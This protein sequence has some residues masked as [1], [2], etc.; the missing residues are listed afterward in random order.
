MYR[1]KQFTELP[2]IKNLSAEDQSREYY[3][4]QNKMMEAIAP[5]AASSAAAGAGGAGGSRRQ[6][7]T[8]ASATIH[9]RLLNGLFEYTIINFDLGTSVSNSKQFSTDANLQDYFGTQEGGFIFWIPSDTDAV[10]HIIYIDLSGGITQI[11]IDYS[12]DIYTAFLPKYIIFYY[13]EQLVG[14]RLLVF[15]ESGIRKFTMNDSITNIG[16]WGFDSHF[17]NGFCIETTSDNI[18][19]LYSV[20]DGSSTPNMIQQMDNDIN[21]WNV[22]MHD[23]HEKIMIRRSNRSLD[24]IDEVKVID[25]NGNTLATLDTRNLASVRYT[26]QSGDTKSQIATSQGCTV[27]LLEYLNPTY[28]LD[29]LVE[30]DIING[31]VELYWD[32]ITYLNSNDNI[33]ILLST[34]ELNGYSKRYVVLYDDAGG[35]FSVR[36]IPYNSNNDYGWWKYHFNNA[37]WDGTRDNKSDSVLFAFYK[38]SESNNDFIYANEILLLPVFATDTEVKNPI[39][40]ASQSDSQSIDYRNRGVNRWNDPMLG[41]NKIS[42]I[43]DDN[44]RGPGIFYFS[45]YGMSTSSI[46][47]GGL[48]MFDTGNIIVADSNTINYTHTQV[49]QPYGVEEGGSSYTMGLPVGYFRMDGAD[50]YD[51]NLGASSSYFTNLYPGLFVF[52]ARNV[53]INQF[54]ITGSTGHDNTGMSYSTNFQITSS[55]SNIYQ[56]FVKCLHETPNAGTSEP[57]INQIIIVNAATASGIT[58]DIGLTTDDDTHILTGLTGVTQVHYLLLSQLYNKRMEDQE[59]VDVARTYINMVDTMSNIETIVELNTNYRAITSILENNSVN[60]TYYT[61]DSDGN[62]ETKIVDTMFKSETLNYTWNGKTITRQETRQY[63][64]LYGETGWTNL[65]DVSKRSWTTFRRALNGQVGNKAVNTELVMWSLETDN[66]YKIDITSWGAESGG[67]FAYTRQLITQAMDEPVIAFTHSISTYFDSV[68][69]IEPGILEISRGTWGPLVNVARQTNPY[70]QGPVGTLWNSEYSTQ[71]NYKHILFDAE[72]NYDTISFIDE[73]KEDDWWLDT[74]YSLDSISS[75]TYYSNDGKWQVLDERYNDDYS[76]NDYITS[77]RYNLTNVLLTNEKTKTARILNKDGITGTFSILVGDTDTSFRVNRV[78]VGA[79]NILII[80]NVATPG[81]EYDT[82]HITVYD[83]SGNILDTK[84][85][86]NI[87]DGFSRQNKKNRLFVTY[88]DNNVRKVI[89]FLNG[90]LK[91]VVDTPDAGNNYQY[92]SNDRLD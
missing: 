24:S 70:N 41:T 80:T 40:F 73:P 27:A 88:R 82:S 10:D 16:F 79:D 34:S 54:G 42:M 33:V 1:W 85:V 13:F 63:L 20:L 47:D 30:G 36:T 21:Y 90:S 89:A 5:A 77:D 72:G 8:N 66:Y 64:D 57:S 4:Y 2:K 55:A 22:Y 48:D 32:E 31:F 15:D 62:E 69:V 49:E 12:I 86:T 60:Y 92:I 14:Y 37:N 84:S 52:S 76:F 68:D 29:N 81:E 71:W 17:L 3:R 61:I 78:S 23:L 39:V 7:S 56:V 74:F 45:D 58:Q 44:R 25:K 26:I 59:L 53:D 18:V 91:T 51:T 28:D 83:L 87:S 19:S 67:A 9:Y 43:I 75:K 38:S 35:T 11:D 46:D 50:T 6:T 65:P